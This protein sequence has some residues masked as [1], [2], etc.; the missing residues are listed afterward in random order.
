MSYK[1][2]SRVAMIDMYGKLYFT[3]KIVRDWNYG[4]INTKSES[5]IFEQSTLIPEYQ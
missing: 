1:V 5:F 3:A 2:S 4:M